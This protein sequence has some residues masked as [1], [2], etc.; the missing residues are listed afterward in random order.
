MLKRLIL[1]LFII[2]LCAGCGKSSQPTL[3]SN[4]LERK[5]DKIQVAVSILPQADFVKSIGKDK[6]RVVVM[7]P[8][9]ASPATYEPTPSQLKELSQ[10]D[11]Y[12]KIGNLPFEKAWLNKIISANNKMKVVNSSEGI[13]I[14]GDNPHIWLSPTLVKKQIDNIYEGLV[15]VDPKNKDYYAVN[16]EKYIKD[17]DELDKEIRE[18]V[19]NIKNKKFMVFHPAWGY[20]AKDYGLEEIAIEVEGKEPSPEDIIKFIELAKKNEI[21]AIFV[22]PQFNTESAE[23]IAKEINGKVVFADPLAQDYIKNMKAISKTLAQ[24]LK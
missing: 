8:P 5:D 9:G 7:I 16:K 20:F 4:Q 23:V 19:K 24:S 17:L 3:N 18:A 1:T 6:V 11:M 10:A 2:V 13:K 14:I 15:E 21:K 12:V 22:S